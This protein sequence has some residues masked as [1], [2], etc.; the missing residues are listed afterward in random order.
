VRA[1]AW[2][3]QTRL[4]Q[5]YRHMMARGKPAQVIVT[6]IARELARFVW[7]IACMMKRGD[8]VFGR[9]D[10]YPTG[11]TKLFLRKHLGCDARLQGVVT[12]A[13]RV[14]TVFRFSEPYF[15]I[16]PKGNGDLHGPSTSSFEHIVW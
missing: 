5:R 1:I 8:S 3:A 10:D 15:K 11:H 16:A 2:K 4:C 6:A 14:S 7:S 13:P 9:L 12:R